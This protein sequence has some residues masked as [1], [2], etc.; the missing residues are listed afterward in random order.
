MFS[1][2][3]KT[4]KRMFSCSRDGRKI[5]CEMVTPA[6]EG[7]FPLVVWAHPFGD[8]SHVIDHT[9]AAQHGIAV[10]AFDFC[11][12]AP[13]SRSDGASTDISVVTE[14]ADLQTVLK[15]MTELPEVDPDR[16]YLMGMSQGGYVATM[17]A[18][19]GTIRIAGMLLLCPA[20]VL[21]DLREQMFGRREVPE[22]FRARNMN[23]GRRY[24]RDLE[25]ISIYELM[26]EYP[27]PVLIL[28]GDGDELVPAAYI[29]R[30]L[31][32]FPNARLVTVKGAGH[33]DLPAKREE[34]LLNT[35]VDFVQGGCN[36][37][38]AG[39]GTD[40]TGGAEMSAA[41]STHAHEHT[42]TDENG[43]TWTHTHDHDHAHS[44][45]HDHT[46][47][48]AH[49][50]T[51]TDENGNTWTHTHDHDHAHSE[52]HNHDHS[53]DHPHPHPHEHAQED[54]AAGDPAR[55]M[56]MIKYMYNHNASHL[57][58]LMDTVGMLR[59]SG[60]TVQAIKLEGAAELFKLAN[61]VLQEVL[62]DLQEP[63][64]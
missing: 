41:E 17:I 63:E 30:A 57:T 19:L 53:G 46:H 61:R 28:H 33:D 56:A 54:G 55:A 15:K 50:H 27:G 34:M 3:E 45:D 43:N 9:E 11:G 16:I 24:V 44:E 52:D 1:N 29:E 2:A 14:A 38:E 20:Y 60:N 47:E 32:K 62:T 36:T 10:C 8:N 42:H 49:E 31:E 25:Q 18:G 23:L 5:F 40:G 26:P 6:G 39:C 12:G 48:H 59:V 51:H 13:D 58:E 7:P 4:R 22:R 35:L 37:T 21:E 64:K